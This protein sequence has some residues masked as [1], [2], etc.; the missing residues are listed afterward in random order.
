MGGFGFGLGFG[1]FG[2]DFV[3]FRGLVLR[4]L[5]FVVLWLGCCCFRFAVTGDGWGCLTASFVDCC[6]IG[7]LSLRVLNG[8]CDLFCGLVVGCG[9][10]TIGFLGCG[11]LLD[12]WYLVFLSLAIWWFG[13]WMV[14]AYILGGVFWTGGVLVFVRVGRFVV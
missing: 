8:C 14:V 1:C 3:G 7:L 6:C 10:L 4:V 13:C 5:G 2:L 9:V 11:V 12:S